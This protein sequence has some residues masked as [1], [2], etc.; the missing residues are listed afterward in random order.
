M[1][2][3]QSYSTTKKSLETAMKYITI[4]AVF[5]AWFVHL[6]LEGT[7]KPSFANTLSQFWAQKF[8]C[9]RIGKH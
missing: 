3:C 4:E 8:L 7:N 2:K 9:D 6:T 5:G 1:G